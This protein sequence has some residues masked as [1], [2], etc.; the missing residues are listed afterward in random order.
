MDAAVCRY[1][2]WQ[3]DGVFTTRSVGGGVINY[4]NKKIDG[5]KGGGNRAHGDSGRSY[6][7]DRGSSIVVV[8]CTRQQQGTMY[9]VLRTM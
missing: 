7:V 1:H 9:N 5:W 4:N 2:G 6:R 8:D 3:M